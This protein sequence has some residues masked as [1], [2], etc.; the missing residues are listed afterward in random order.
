MPTE[1]FFHRWSR[2][3]I[4]PEA[5]SA[6]PVPAANAVP[7]SAAA[8]PAPAP[9][10]VRQPK[11]PTL[12]DVAALGADSDYS[13]FVAHGVDKAV[14]RSAMKK[15]FSDPHFNLGDGLDIYM[16]DYNK[17]DPIPA[18]MLAA[19]RHSQSFFAQAFPDKAEGEG[20]QDAG[21]D[22]VRV[23]EG[24]TGQQAQTEPDHQGP[25]IAGQTGAPDA[26]KETSA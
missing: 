14:Q 10:E 21:Q 13:A 17:P 11:L 8:H 15:L 7:A 26:V 5:A 4:E 22:E 12:A 16:G 3:K 6:E 18:V 2:L 25:Q 9:A 1:G 20:V 23:A 24:A 19:L